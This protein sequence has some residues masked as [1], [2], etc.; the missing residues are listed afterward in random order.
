MP[1][2]EDRVV[3]FDEPHALFARHGVEDEISRALDARW[4]SRCGG[5]IVIEQTE[6][7]TTIDVNTGGF[8]GATNLED[9]VFRT[10]LEAAAVIPRQLRLRNLGGII[11][12]DFIDMVDEE[13]QPA[14][15]ARARAGMRSGSGACAVVRLFGARPRRDE[16]QT[17]ARES[18][19]ADLSSLCDVRQGRGVV[20]TAETV[21]FEVFRAILED[22]RKRCDDAPK[23]CRRATG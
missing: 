21:C 7:M 23:T 19:P 10:N 12:I 5:Y 4:A 16:P 8:V 2:F 11:V 17:D 20:K 13:H 3:L 9:T 22:A 1:D 14:G 6:A 18:R 15:D